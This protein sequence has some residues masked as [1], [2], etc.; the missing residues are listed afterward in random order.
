MVDGR[1]ETKQIDSVDF[2]R[3]LG[4]FSVS[5]INRPAW[6]DKYVADSIFDEQKQLVHL[7]ITSLDKSLKTQSIAVD[8]Q[9]GAIS[10][11][12]IH[13]NT[14]N[15]IASSNQVLTYEPSSGYSIE[16]N[17][18]VTFSDAQDFRIHVMFLK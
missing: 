9:Q 8:F 4:M 14:T 3:E 6:S 7:E 13:N 11:V 16:S 15:S 12:Q 2:Q 1:E 18:K 17:Q 5:D 10:K